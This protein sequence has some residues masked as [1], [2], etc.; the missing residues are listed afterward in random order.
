MVLY[1]SYRA[2]LPKG[3]LG[4]PQFLFGAK[5]MPTQNA[6]ASALSQ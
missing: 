5:L 6:D 1:I 3:I 4:S 2:C